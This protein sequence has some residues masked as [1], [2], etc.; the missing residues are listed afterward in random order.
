MTHDAEEP[1][2]TR[3]AVLITILRT[4]FSKFKQIMK[5][6][7]PKCALSRQDVLTW[8]VRSNRKLGPK[9][10]AS[11][12]YLFDGTWAISWRAKFVVRFPHR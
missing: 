5:Q 1:I 4:E 8:D 10:S 7:D 11:W 3:K 9:T 12:F 6:V 2:F